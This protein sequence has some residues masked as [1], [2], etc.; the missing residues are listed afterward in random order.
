MTVH[1]IRIMEWKKDEALKAKEI[2]E[3]KIME[4]DF[5]AAHRFAMVARNL[6]PALDGLPQ[7]MATIETYVSAQKK[8]NG[9]VDWY[10]VLNIDPSA[11]DD[12]I[13]KSF[14]KL[15]LAIDQS[16]GANGALKIISEAWSTLSDKFKRAAFDQRRNFRGLVF[17]KVHNSRISSSSYHNGF[18]GYGPWKNPNHS[19][20]ASASTS[21]PQRTFWTVCSACKMQFEFWSEYRNCHLRCPTCR[22]SF[23][24]TETPSPITNANGSCMSSEM[25]PSSNLSDKSA[26]ANGRL[27]EFGLVGRLSAPTSTDSLYGKMSGTN[28]SS[29]SHSS[30]QLKRG[31]GD[32]SLHTFSEETHQQIHHSKKI[33]RGSGG[34]SSRVSVRYPLAPERSRKKKQVVQRCIKGSE[35]VGDDMGSSYNF[36]K[37]NMEAGKLKT[38]GSS[39]SR[40]TTNMPCLDCRIMLIEK[41]KK[42]IQQKVSVWRME[43]EIAEKSFSSKRINLT[44]P[45]NE[46]KDYPKECKHHIDHPGPSQIAKF[47]LT[48]LTKS[49]IDL[50]KSMSVSDPDF[51]DFDQGRVE[52]SF[53]ANQVWAAYDDDDGMPRYYA[54][55]HNVLSRKP[56]KMQMSW[57]SSKTTHEFGPLR[58]VEFGYPKTCGDLWIRKYEVYDSLNCFSHKVKWKKGHRGVIQI[59]PAKGDVWALY[60]NWSPDWNE[61]TPDD[62]IHNYDMVEVLGDYS[63]ESGVR[64]APLLKVCGFKTVFQTNPDQTKIWNVSREEMFR[65]SHQVPARVLTGEEG[66]NAPKGFWELDPASTPVE[67]LKVLTES[68][69]EEMVNEN[70]EKKGKG[71][72]TKEKEILV[73]E[74]RR[75]GTKQCGQS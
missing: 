54:I 43:K 48:N 6:Y 62:V 19:N 39:W 36:Q 55:I 30:G 69:L 20:C 65:F 10:K 31:N 75:K 57:L 60:R 11:D 32:S 53:Q 13:R 37:V 58:W 51:Y 2:A 74:R 63:E 26:P 33:C 35:N 73:Y 28:F 45:S 72:E 40:G 59:Y 66:P 34:I 56:F 25:N 18:Y 27:P 8:I 3:K 64:V 67:L 16:V 61:L 23:L 70:V 5:T 15:A 44:A 17:E 9:E 49:E 14:R 42:E 46:E 68:E 71:K 41:A 50:V 22:H 24:A 52:S 12:T 21:P 7:L 38:V 29:P 4:I 1:E 47:P